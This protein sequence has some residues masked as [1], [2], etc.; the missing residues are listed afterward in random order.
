MNRVANSGSSCL[1][2]HTEVSAI[3]SDNTRGCAGGLS[4]RRASCPG[5][6]RLRTT[7][8][9]GELRCRLLG[10]GQERAWRAHLRH[11]LLKVAPIACHQPDA[12]LPGDHLAE[13]GM[14]GFRRTRRA[15]HC[16]SL[17]EEIAVEVEGR[18]G[19]HVVH[20]RGYLSLECVDYV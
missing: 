15:K 7:T 10:L 1:C 9:R 2:A 16:G 17:N 18:M 14:D 4:A 12:R 3:S 13:R 11:Q 5:G 20:P 6:S 8:R 19:L